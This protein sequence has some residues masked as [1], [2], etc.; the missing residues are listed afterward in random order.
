MIR[1]FL[2]SAVLPLLPMNRR[3]YTSRETWWAAEARG[4]ACC[5]R[6]R[7]RCRRAVVLLGDS[8]SYVAGN[9]VEVMAGLSIR[10]RNVELTAEIGLQNER[11]GG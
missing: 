8:E 4:A 10:G 3:P 6:V 11:R 7:R 1:L 5:R 2:E 9:A